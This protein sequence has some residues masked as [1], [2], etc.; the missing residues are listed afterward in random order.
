[1]DE[2]YENKTP[3]GADMK[4]QVQQRISAPKFHSA[5]VN[6]KSMR[7]RLAVCYRM[8]SQEGAFSDAGPEVWALRQE[9]ES[10]LPEE[11]QESI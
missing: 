6:A 10:H 1:M 5:L 9:V 11:L 4:L 7:A 3:I 2:Y 8:L